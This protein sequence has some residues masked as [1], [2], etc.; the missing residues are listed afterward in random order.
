MSEMKN[1]LNGINIRLDTAEEKINELEDLI[2]GTIEGLTHR[3]KKIIKKNRASVSYGTSSSIRYVSL[4]SLRE[5][6]ERWD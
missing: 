6:R 4:E 5:R 1:T 2:I 3:G